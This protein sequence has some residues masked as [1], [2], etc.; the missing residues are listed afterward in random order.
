MFIMSEIQLLTPNQRMLVDSITM[1]AIQ[2][3]L[4]GRYT[5]SLR[6]RIERLRGFNNGE[7]TFIQGSFKI[8]AKSDE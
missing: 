6:E 7:N 3:G 1:Q 4:A 2:N 8:W 5:R